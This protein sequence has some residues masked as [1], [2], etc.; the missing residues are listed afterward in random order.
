MR[1]SPFTS[2][3]LTDTSLRFMSATSTVALHNV[4]CF[5]MKICASLTK[6]ERLLWVVPGLWRR[7][8]NFLPGNLLCWTE[9]PGWAK[10]GHTD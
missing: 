6:A 5:L 10:S 8:L 4:V 1:G 7:P 9:R 2:L 3:T